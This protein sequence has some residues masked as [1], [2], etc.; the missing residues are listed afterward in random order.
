MCKHGVLAN[1][2]RVG[3]TDDDGHPFEEVVAL[4][5]GGPVARRIQADLR[6][7]LLDSAE[8]GDR[9]DRMTQIKSENLTNHMRAPPASAM[10][11]L[12]RL[13]RTGP[14]ATL[15]RKV[16]AHKPSD[17]LATNSHSAPWAGT[18]RLRLSRSPLG[19][20]HI[21]LRDRCACGTACCT[22]TAVAG[23]AA[24]RPR[25]KLRR[26]GCHRVCAAPRLAKV[27]CGPAAAWVHR[28]RERTDPL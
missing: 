19:G 14:A 20:E 1:L 2:R 9:R 7:L 25:L 4:G 26:G 28:D 8:Q 11:I 21:M 22:C 23:R 13:G 12:S 5:P 24:T 6:K 18:M 15:E 17:A 16:L 3:G 10:R 27:P